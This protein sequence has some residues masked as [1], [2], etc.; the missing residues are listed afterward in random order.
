MHALQQVLFNVPGQVVRALRHGGGHG[1]T[2]AVDE[3]GA[4][5]VRA[6]RAARV[7]VAEA[8]RQEAVSERAPRHAV[9]GHVLERPPGRAQLYDGVAH[10]GR[11]H[12]AAGTAARLQHRHLADALRDQ[13]RRGAQPR[14]ARAEHH[15]LGVALGQ[16]GASHAEPAGNGRKMHLV[17]SVG[18]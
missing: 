4:G 14:H 7:A 12:A 17:P 2:L 5:R 11:L 8:V 1:H 9:V 10:E 15:H 16:V 3:Q 6:H 13:V 18:V